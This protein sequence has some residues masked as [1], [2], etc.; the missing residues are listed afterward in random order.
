MSKVCFSFCLF[1]AQ[2]TCSRPVLIR[3]SPK[4]V[5][6]FIGGQARDNA[7]RIKAYRFQEPGVTRINVQHGNDASVNDDDQ[8]I[9]EPACLGCLAVCQLWLCGTGVLEALRCNGAG[10]LNSRVSRRGMIA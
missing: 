2:R 10:Q 4:L 6:L 7:Q 8:A 9:R 5:W 1:F 3:L